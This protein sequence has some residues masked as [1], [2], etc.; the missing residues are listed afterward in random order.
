MGQPNFQGDAMSIMH[1]SKMIWCVLKDE[2]VLSTSKK[3]N[4][5]DQDSSA[6]GL[7]PCCQH[8][9]RPALEKC[10][11]ANCDDIKLLA[12]EDHT[13]AHIHSQTMCRPGRPASLNTRVFNNKQQH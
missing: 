13:F 3:L 4:R 1:N 6:K 11:E 8:G 7:I 9:R 5:E 2:I 10:E 12:P